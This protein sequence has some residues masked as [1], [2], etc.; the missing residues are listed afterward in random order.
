MQMSPWEFDQSPNGWRKFEAS[1]EYLKAANLIGDYI[2]ANRAKILHPPASERHTGINIMHFHIGQLLAFV[3]PEYYPEAIEAFQKSFRERAECWNA[4]VSATIGFLENDKDKIDE[5]V[6]TIEG[7]QEGDKR[8]GNI[9][10]VMSFKE[11]LN[12]GSRNY[13]E[14]YIRHRTQG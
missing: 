14:A 12:A 8:S 5:A 9:G 2:K 6:R 10:I 1:R 4:Y 3:G 7:S 11:A 13:R